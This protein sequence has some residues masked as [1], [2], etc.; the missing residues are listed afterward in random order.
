[1]NDALLKKINFLRKKQQDNRE[2][3][4]QLVKSNQ[5]LESEIFQILRQ[6]NFLR[7]KANERENQDFS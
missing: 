6:N 1:M 7:C 5:N 3:I 2:H 4:I